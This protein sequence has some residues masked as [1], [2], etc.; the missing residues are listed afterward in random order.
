LY[1]NFIGSCGSGVLIN[2]IKQSVV[3]G[4]E[5]RPNKIELKLNKNANNI[6]I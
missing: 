5:P 6:S 4:K 2:K 1:S 3:Q